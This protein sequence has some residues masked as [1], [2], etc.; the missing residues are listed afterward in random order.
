MT[1][2]I[3]KVVWVIGSTLGALWLKSDSTFT[4]DK[5]QARRFESYTDALKVQRML[6][7]PTQLMDYPA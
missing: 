3:N 7:T 6:R 2:K 4:T 5:T 1:V